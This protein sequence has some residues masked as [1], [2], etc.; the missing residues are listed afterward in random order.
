MI[1]AAAEVFTPHHAEGALTAAP[2]VTTEE[3]VMLNHMSCDRDKAPFK[4]HILVGQRHF[5]LAIRGC[6]PAVHVFVLAK[7]QYIQHGL[8]DVDRSHRVDHDS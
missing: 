6:L 8:M 4:L 1:S 3:Q 5:L 7:L 2:L